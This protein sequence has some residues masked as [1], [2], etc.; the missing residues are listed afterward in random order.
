MLSERA[1]SELRWLASQHRPV[2]GG[3]LERGQSLDDSDLKDWLSL[4][5][6]E[7]SGMGYIITKAGRISCGAD[8]P[9]CKS[10]GREF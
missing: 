9:R 8:L 2:W 3:H 4:G 5:L 10:C 7:Q 6:V 1:K